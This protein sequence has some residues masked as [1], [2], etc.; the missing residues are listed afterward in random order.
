MYL[1]TWK[2][3]L[4]H[5]KPKYGSSFAEPD[6][7]TACADSSL[8][9]TPGFNRT[10]PEG[11]PYQAFAAAAT[12][13]SSA[14]LDA[15]AATQRAGP[16]RHVQGRAR[17]RG[18]LPRLQGG[19]VNVSLQVRGRAATTPLSRAT[20]RATPVPPPRR[21]PIGSREAARARGEAAPRGASGR[22]AVGARRA[23]PPAAAAAPPAAARSAALLPAR[24]PPHPALLARRPSRLPAPGRCPAGRLAAR[25]M[26]GN[27]MSAPLPAIVPAARKA[28]AAVSAGRGASRGEAPA[29]RGPPWRLAAPAALC[30]LPWPQPRV[31]GGRSGP[32]AWRRRRGYRPGGEG[33]WR[34]GPRRLTGLP[35]YLTTG[36]GPGS[37]S[38]RGRSQRRRGKVTG[39]GGGP[40]APC[41][42]PGRARPLMAAWRPGERWVGSEPSGVFLRESR[43]VLRTPC[44]FAWALWFV[45]WVR[46]LFSDL[47]PPWCF[48]CFVFFL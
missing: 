17:N 29:G 8:F 22:G 6:F 38:T 18:S 16:G 35:C 34:G 11:F 23:P 19:R 26:C 43:V 28:T 32:A 5:W 20:A 45:G 48:C 1:A 15:A 14:A 44:D 40:A 3:V 24:R 9:N 21:Q 7:Q 42:G 12:H 4:K 10:F 2:R 46:L 30:S 39:V 47:K 31:G 37:R 33:V 41:G 27:N 13:E 36:S 25:C